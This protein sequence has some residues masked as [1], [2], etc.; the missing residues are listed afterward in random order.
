[1][2]RRRFLK[3]AGATAAIAGGSA[4][5]LDYIARP[6]VPPVVS[7]TASGYSSSAFPITSVT[8]VPTTT[9]T[10]LATTR[11]S[12]TETGPVIVW[13]PDFRDGTLDGFRPATLDGSVGC[14]DFPNKPSDVL[15]SVVDD[16]S[17]PSGSGKSLELVANVNNRNGIFVNGITARN[18]V[19][20]DNYRWTA[21]G[22]F[23]NASGGTGM[24]DLAIQQVENC[25]ESAADVAWILF[26]DNQYEGKIVARVTQK[27]RPNPKIIVLDSLPNDRQWH[28]F[29]IQNSYAASPKSR[30][31]K[32]VRLDDKSYSLNE[33][34][35]PIDISWQSSFMVFLETH[36]GYTGC[37]SQKAFQGRSRWNKIRFEEEPLTA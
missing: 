31:L 22:W 25:K 28:Y 27:E 18:T 10:S 23:R 1:L 26:R 34:I 36:N 29:E 6:R 14:S 21:S 2:N 11:T 13:E 16:S 15:A 32:N 37:N 7:Q 17:A 35:L 4:L 9:A 12:T 24:I 20:S 30:I 19:F 33:E 5:G 3:Y 8:K